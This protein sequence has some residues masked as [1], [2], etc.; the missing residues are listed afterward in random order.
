MNKYLVKLS[1]NYYYE[2]EIIADN[3]EEAEQIGNNEFDE[4]EIRGH[5]LYD[6]FNSSVSLMEEL[7]DYESWH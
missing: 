7:D 5:E 1:R 4:L 2:T 3:E 6:D